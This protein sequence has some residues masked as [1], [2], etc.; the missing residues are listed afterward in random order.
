VSDKILQI[1]PAV[2]W[3]AAY[4]DK[5]DAT[6]FYR[7]V[8]CWALVHDEAEND[9]CVKGMDAADYIDF[10]EESS[11]F[12]YYIHEAELDEDRARQAKGRE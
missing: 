5:E 10:I 4:E 7:P 2:G 1:I 3:Y 11:S 6:T 9:R 8:V 12:R